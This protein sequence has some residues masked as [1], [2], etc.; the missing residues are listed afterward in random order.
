MIACRRPPLHGKS[1]LKDAEDFGV[2]Q[3]IRRF[4]TLIAVVSFAGRTEFRDELG[5]RFIAT[6]LGGLPLV[7]KNYF[8]RLASCIVVVTEQSCTRSLPKQMDGMA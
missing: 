2:G 8:R 4:G 3:G 5:Q 1:P 6:V 7:N